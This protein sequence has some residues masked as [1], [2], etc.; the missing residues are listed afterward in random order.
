[1]K[2]K[3]MLAG[4]TAAAL[5]VSAMAFSSLTA[6]AADD[7]PEIWVT[8]S[9]VKFEIEKKGDY[10]WEG[11]KSA[12]PKSTDIDLTTVSAMKAADVKIKATWGSMVVKKD[13]E[14]ISDSQFVIKV[15]SE[16]H[17]AGNDIGWD[18]VYSGT[19]T[20]KELIFT[21][22]SFKENTPDTNKISSIEYTVG[23]V[24]DGNYKVGDKLS[25]ELT[26]VKIE[27]TAKKPADESTGDDYVKWTAGATDSTYKVASK[28]GYD[29]TK[30]TAEEASKEIEIAKLLKTGKKAADV[31]SIKVTVDGLK[32]KEEATFGVTANYVT[33]NGPADKSNNAMK[34]SAT[35][36]EASLDLSSGKGLSDQKTI[37]LSAMTLPANSELTVTV[38]F[39]YKKVYEEKDVQKD[40]SVTVK[41]EDLNDVEKGS[42]INLDDLK[43]SEYKFKTEDEI[44]FTVT[45]GK[46][47]KYD[48]WVL[49]FNG[50][51]GDTWVASTA[52]EGV[53]KY[54]ATVA[55][56][57]K[58]VGIESVDK[59]DGILVQISHV[60]AD[61]TFTYTLTVKSEVV[62]EEPDD[63]GDSGN[64]G[65]GGTTDNGN[66]GNTSA[67][68]VSG[69]KHQGIGMPPVVIS[70]RSTTSAST[71][72]A[73][74]GSTSVTLSNSTVVSKDA[75]DSV[76]GKD[77]EFKLSNGASWEIAAADAA[78]AEGMDLGITLNTTAATADQLKEVA[79]D[80]DT[81]QFSLAY[82]GD[83]GF[84]AVIN[85]PVDAKNNGKYAN[86][87]WF[88]N[89]KFEF[90]GSSKVEGGIADFTMKHASDYVIV[91]DDEAYGEDVSSGAG[92]Y[93]EESETSAPAAVVV[94]FA[95]LAVSAVILKKRVF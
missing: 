7:A 38:S 8:E 73:A 11:T 17:G 44:T 83:F 80:N 46:D 68:T 13:G 65:N 1:M 9:S 95:A 71:G 81:F 85:I 29:N 22:E 86:L 15:N 36:K 30:D 90:I 32:D 56:I 6:S 4:I 67:P 92:V 61:D 12:M 74:S 35:T 37:T 84:S 26:D 42:Y 49:T 27:V 57:V 52:G 64:G 54:T 89:G 39:V 62:E 55:D 88:N 33:E 93:E 19:K 60:A 53:L 82:S 94:T 2:L 28:S 45:P 14:P 59:L 76:A 43:N 63:S 87:Y 70:N 91:F 23:V 25:V 16:P 78:K 21:K 18:G 47:V 31:D 58:A 79:Q 40:K 75:I 3:R 20:E 10:Y 50:H 72:T 24:N 5:A 34:F 48:K 51:S 69:N 77:A 41:K 66:S